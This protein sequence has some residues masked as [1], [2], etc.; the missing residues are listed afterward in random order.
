MQKDTE[1]ALAAPP[2]PL[3]L[4]TKHIFIEDIKGVRGCDPFT[5]H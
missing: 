1:E 3:E 4:L 2:T 5:T